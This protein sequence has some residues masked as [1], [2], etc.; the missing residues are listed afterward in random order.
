MAGDSE[1]ISSQRCLNFWVIEVN[2]CSL[3]GK[4][5]YLQEKKKKIQYLMQSNRIFQFNRKL[6]FL[7][8]QEDLLI[9]YRQV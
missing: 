1:S 2:D 9:I 5:V 3:I 6:K 4:H 7:K 8:L